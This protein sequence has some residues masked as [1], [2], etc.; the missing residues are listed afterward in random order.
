MNSQMGSHG[1]IGLIAPVSTAN[2]MQDQAIWAQG[3]LLLILLIININY[4]G[5]IL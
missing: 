4:I 1:I 3:P 2:G 5:Q